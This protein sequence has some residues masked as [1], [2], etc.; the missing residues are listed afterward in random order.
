VLRFAC[1]ATS[2]VTTLAG[3]PAMAWAEPA[4]VQTPSPDG[5]P[6]VDS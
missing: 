1:V 3:A 2:V 6:S 5:E 4:P